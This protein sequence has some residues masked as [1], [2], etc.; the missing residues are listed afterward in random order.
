MGRDVYNRYISNAFALFYHFSFY[1]VNIS[2]N[3]IETCK[4]AFDE[5]KYVISLLNWGRCQNGAR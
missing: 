1:S 2:V 5:K 3:I 4:L